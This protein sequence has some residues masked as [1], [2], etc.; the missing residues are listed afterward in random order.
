MMSDCMG[1]PT[2]IV[3]WRLGL[4]LLVVAPRAGTALEDGHIS[5]RQRRVI[6]SMIESMGIDPAV[7]RRM[8]ENSLAALSGQRATMDSV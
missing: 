6:D 2:A 8:E 4:Y 5:E 3:A 1:I 7:A